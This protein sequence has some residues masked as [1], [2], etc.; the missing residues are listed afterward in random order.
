[1]LFSTKLGKIE[2]EKS[3]IVNFDT[4]IPGFENWRQFALIL[5][6]ETQPIQWLISLE[7]MEIAFPVIDPWLVKKDY[8]FD[9]SQEVVDRLDIRDKE[10]ILVITMVRIPQDNPLEMTVNLLAPVII[11][12]ENRQAIQLV[13]DRSDYSLRHHIR[14]EIRKIMITDEGESC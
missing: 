3:E 4:G 10:K 14:D 1:M 12:T 8:S 5:L 6:P 9:I 13:L 11:N 7:N 2:V